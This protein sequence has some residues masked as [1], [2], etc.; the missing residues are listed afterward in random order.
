MT[1]ILREKFFNRPA[2]KVS[3]DLLGKF[4]I[5]RLNGDPSSRK[6]TKDKNVAIM[7]TETEAYVGPEDKASHASRGRTQRNTPMFGKPGFFY[8]YFTYGMHWMLNVVTGR[9]GFPAAVLIRGGI[10]ISD[11]EP[12]RYGASKKQD[13]RLTINGP[14]KLTKFLKIDKCFNG[15]PVNRRTGLWLEDRG[16]KLRSS[17]IKRGPRVGVDYAGKWARKNYN[18]RLKLKPTKEVRK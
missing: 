9:E 11:P 7:I 16:L 3:R 14:A 2:L 13:T 15:K 12:L 17:Q 6:A 18:F 5:R 1:K 10:V 8:I 4:L